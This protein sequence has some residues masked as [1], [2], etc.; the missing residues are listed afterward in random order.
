MSSKSFR[1]YVLSLVLLVEDRINRRLAEK[2]EVMFDR[3]TDGN[4]LYV[5]MIQTYIFDSV[6]Y[7]KMLA[8]APLFQKDDL[9]ATQHV[10]FFDDSPVV[11]SK[12]F[13]NVSC[14]IGDNSSVSQ[15]ILS[16]TCIPVMAA[17]A[18]YST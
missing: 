2:F 3:W 7:E 16:L 11:Y 10:K 18:T 12:S 6:C 5:S 14:F 9:S 15:K 4:I 8:C 1:K 13:S 17:V